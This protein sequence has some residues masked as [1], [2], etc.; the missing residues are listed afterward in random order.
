MLGQAGAGKEDSEVRRSKKRRLEELVA[1]SAEL[2]AELKRIDCNSSE[3]TERL[4]EGIKVCARRAY[5][6]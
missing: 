6:S 1:A 4:E 5:R 2:D 3:Y